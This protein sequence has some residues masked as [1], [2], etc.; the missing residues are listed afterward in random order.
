MSHIAP[1][2]AIHSVSLGRSRPGLIDRL[3]RHFARTEAALDGQSRRAALQVET[4]RDTGLT[5]DDLT[6]APSHNP[7]LPF[8]MQSGFGRGDW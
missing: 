3:R 2:A 8:F 5:P 4:L 6:G 1:V 7:A